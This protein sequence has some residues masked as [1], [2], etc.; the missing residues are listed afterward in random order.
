MYVGSSRKLAPDFAGGR[1]LER[2]ITRRIRHPSYNSEKIDYD[3]LV[4][5][6]KTPVLDIKPALLNEDANVPIEAQALTVIGYGITTD[7][8]WSGP[9][10]LLEVDVNYVPPEKCYDGETNGDTMM[11]AATGQLEGTCNGDSGGPLVIKDG[12]TFIQV[13]IVSWG[14]LNKCGRPDSP[15]VYSRV[16][17]QIDWIKSQICL[18]S[19]YPPDYCN[20]ASMRPAT[21]AVTVPPVSSPSFISFPTAPTFSF[22]P[23]ASPIVPS[24]SPVAAPSPTSSKECADSGD[25]FS[26]DFLLEKKDCTW[27]AEN[28]SMIGYLCR[29]LDVAAVC[30]KTC[31][32]C[33]YFAVCP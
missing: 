24:S 11:C 3:Y 22:P 30:K 1:G 29:Y 2:T 23:I 33:Q 16:S 15:G 7:F 32:A 31:D 26:V 21:A 5:K 19:E 8:A 14:I 4:M 18:L 28:Q 13:G 12:D 10:T 27:L 25:T 17:G 20:A 9:N 6:L